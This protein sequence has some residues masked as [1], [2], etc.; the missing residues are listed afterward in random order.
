MDTQPEKYANLEHSEDDPVDEVNHMEIMGGLA[1]EPKE[2]FIKVFPENV[3]LN[4]FLNNSNVREQAAYV[5]SV[6]YPYWLCFMKVDMKRL[7]MKPRRVYMQLMCDAV[8]G[9]IIQVKS[10]ERIIFDEVNPSEVNVIPCAK[11]Q[12]EGKHLCWD[13][14]K[15]KIIRKYRSWW[16]PDIVVDL[17][18]LVYVKHWV[19]KDKYGK[20]G[21]YCNS[22]DGS[23]KKL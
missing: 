18:Y 8:N 21:Y 11:D 10:D 13:M 19:T 4:S 5:G 14:C 1:D 23:I 3:S 9:E 7:K 2:G 6:Y 15:R 16:F 12:E 17:S 22:F 20:R